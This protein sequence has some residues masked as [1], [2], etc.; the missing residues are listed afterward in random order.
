METILAIIEIETD[1]ESNAPCAYI[2]QNDGH[3]IDQR[4]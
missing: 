3:N 1:P 4:C 2:W